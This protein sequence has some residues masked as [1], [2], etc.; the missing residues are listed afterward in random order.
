MFRKNVI[1]AVAVGLVAAL[2]SGTPAA[3]G[4]RDCSSL[5]AL[6][7]DRDGTL[8]WHEVRRAAKRLFYKLNNDGDTTLEL[9]EL[10]GRV[11]L[12]SFARANPD[13]DGS[14]DMG[15]WLALVK[16]RFHRA[17]PDGDGTVDCREWNSLRGKRLQRATH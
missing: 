13:R 3:A 16:H 1:A 15:E 12:I 4:H 11:G 17:N 5:H 2:A 10:R 6:N 14:L 9:D 7:P 8:D